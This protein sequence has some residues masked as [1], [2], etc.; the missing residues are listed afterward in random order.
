MR[1]HWVHDYETL[2]NCF[3]AVFEDIKSEETRVFVIHDLRND[4]D[5]F[6]EFLKRNVNDDEWHVSFNGL[7][8][9]GQITQYII[10][11]AEA[12]ADMGGCE[13]ASWIYEKAQYVIETKNSG[14]FLEFSERDMLIN[15]IDVFKLNHWDNPAKRSSLKW[16]QFSMDWYNIMDMPIHHSTLITTFEEIDDIIKYC[17]NDV[18]STKEIMHRS[19]K[20]IALRKSLTDEYNIP[21][22]SASEPRVSKELFT[23]FLSKKTG[24]KRYELK[25]MR[26]NRS[27]II[28]KDILLPYIDFKTA[29]FQRLHEKY[30]NLVVYPDNT[31]GG[32][33]YSIQYKGVKTDFGLGGVHGATNKG[34]YKSD[35]EMIIMSSDVT[36]FYPNLAIR[37]NWSPAHLPKDEFCEQY[38]WFFDERRKISKKDIRNYVYKIILNSTYGLS[39]DRHSF[40]YDPEFTMRIT[41]NGQLSLMM[42]YEMIAENIPGAVPLMQNTD[43]VET[44]IPRKYQDKYLEICKEWEKITNLELEHDTYSKL[45]LAD[46]NN[47][48]AVYNYKEV[49]QKLF[50]ELKETN[51]DDL[52]KEEEGKFYHA[53]TKCKG[54]R[55][56]FHDLPLHK[57]KSF[58]VTRK[59]LFQ[60]FVHGKDL[61]E[62]II[63]NTNIFDFCGAVKVK[64]DWKYTLETI[65]HG[66]F[67]TED[68]QN[69]V[70]YYISNKGGKIM[71][72]NK[73]DERVGQVEAGQWLQTLFI[74][75]EKKPF[76]EYDINYKFYI[77]KARKIKESL[78]PSI[79]QVKLNF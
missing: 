63:N 5:E 70:R 13:I 50:E 29:T 33:K 32:F 75:H 24:I 2:A 15:Q 30:K 67:K 64:G 74:T 1:T 31:K 41:I 65:K 69:T 42:L 58:L 25:K 36:S 47:Y 71:K 43:G 52:F 53:G 78:E 4:L 66:M 59:A 19:K 45:I 60:Y 22:F 17:K 23:Y 72:I 57:N 21:L 49:D 39:N 54:M 56:E 27:S 37:N 76:P 46:V 79:T 51:P 55:F 77:Q 3:V 61:E 48:I 40:L 10:K 73:V 35:N 68:L 11:N 9:D 26:T 62:S 34:V 6:I 7:A 20:Q 18:S 28:V 8:F 38:E 14:S 16:I 12:L 44:I